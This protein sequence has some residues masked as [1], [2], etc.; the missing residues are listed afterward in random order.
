MSIFAK[1][2]KDI[3]L[4]S[5]GDWIEFN[6]WKLKVLEDMYQELLAVENKTEAQQL[7]VDRLNNIIDLVKKQIHPE[8]SPSI[9]LGE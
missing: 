1:I 4:W 5:E 2:G 7:E 8:D 3:S 9:S 6:A